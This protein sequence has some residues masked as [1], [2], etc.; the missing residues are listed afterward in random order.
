MT[1][2]LFF[3]ADLGHFSDFGPWVIFI[4]RPIFSNFRISA[5]CPFYARRSDS[6]FYKPLQRTRLKTLLPQ[7]PSVYRQTFLLRQ[8]ISVDHRYITQT[9]LW[10]CVKESLITPECQA[11]SHRD[12]D[13]ETTIEF[14]NN[15]G[16]NG[17]RCVLA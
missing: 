4:I 2:N 17:K 16:Y 3:F 10:E 5:R 15:F 13:L 14:C 9:C 1:P 6:Q 8:L 12:L 7:W 11:N